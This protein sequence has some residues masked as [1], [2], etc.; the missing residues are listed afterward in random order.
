ME[1]YLITQLRLHLS[2]SHWLCVLSVFCTRLSFLNFFSDFL[3]SFLHLYF[4]LYFF[5]FLPLISLCYFSV[6]LYSFW[7][8]FSASLPYSS[9]LFFRFSSPFSF[10]HILPSFLWFIFGSSIPFF[11]PN[12]SDIIV[13]VVCT[14][15]VLST[16]C[17]LLFCISVF[18]TAL[19]CRKNMRPAA[20]QQSYHRINVLVVDFRVFLCAVM[21]RGF[22]TKVC[23]SAVTHPARRAW[24]AGTH[25]NISH[26]GAIFSYFLLLYCLISAFIFTIPVFTVAANEEVVLG[27][28][29][30][31]RVPHTFIVQG[32]P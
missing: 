1:H 3:V 7:F 19:V 24:H 30:R 29:P 13:Q 31:P 14:L 12:R 15:C 18:A 10:F 20:K 6:L 17:D 21:Y 26:I 25:R 11:P 27:V 9:F 2:C 32:G 22:R 4:S 8:A 5:L 16:T 28:D 23:S